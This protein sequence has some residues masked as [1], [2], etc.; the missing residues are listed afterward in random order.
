MPRGGRGGLGSDA[1][2]AA[3]SCLDSSRLLLVGSVALQACVHFFLQS[4]TCLPLTRV[5]LVFFKVFF[6]VK[7]KD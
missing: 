3:A 7:S 4:A 2:S 1:L 6:L 5:S